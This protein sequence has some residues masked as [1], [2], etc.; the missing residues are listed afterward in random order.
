M[1]QGIHLLAISNTGFDLERFI[2]Q[3]IKAINSSD[4]G[5]LLIIPLLLS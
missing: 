1:N 3:A 4:L 5:F 2:F